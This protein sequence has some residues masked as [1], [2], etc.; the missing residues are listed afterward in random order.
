M[1]GH[2]A[3]RSLLVPG[4]GRRSHRAHVGIGAAVFLTSVAS[5]TLHLGGSRGETASIA[6]ATA[7]SVPLASAFSAQADLDN[8]WAGQ[9]PIP[10]PTVTEA[11]NWLAA[12]W[13]ENKWW[14]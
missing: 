5:V 1:R 10:R 9:P 13:L 8:R 12:I 6:G 4:I 11:T 3:S 2:A 14:L 7:G